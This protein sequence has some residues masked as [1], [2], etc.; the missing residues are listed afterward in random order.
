M[1]PGALGGPF[2]ALEASTLRPS[3]AL[4]GPGGERWGQWMQ[5]QGQRG[6]APLAPALADLL[7]ARRL[8]ASGLAGVV[9]GLGPGS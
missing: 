7:A 5:A 4:L 2:L 1:T 3:V 6:T 8:P 9:V